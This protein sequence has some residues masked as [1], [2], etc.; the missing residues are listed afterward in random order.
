MG[1]IDMVKWLSQRGRL[2][3][4]NQGLEERRRQCLLQANGKRRHDRVLS[5]TYMKK[6]TFQYWYRR[7]SFSEAAL[8][9]TMSV[10]NTW[11]DKKYFHLTLPSS[12]L[13]LKITILCRCPEK[14]PF[15][16][17]IPSGLKRTPS[18]CSHTWLRLAS[19]FLCLNPSTL[20]TNISQ[21]SP[22]H[23]YPNCNCVLFTLQNSAKQ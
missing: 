1:Y 6:G 22:T 14:G 10:E 23:L 5:R 3:R 19:L 12:A 9:K 13:A 8:R 18:S 21:P 16:S 4:H 20:S 17:P 11:K 2:A 7:K 15:L